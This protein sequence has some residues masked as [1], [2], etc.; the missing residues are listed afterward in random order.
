VKKSTRTEAT[1]PVFPPLAAAMTV[2]DGTRGLGEIE[3][4]GRN[5]VRAWLGIGD[6]RVSLGTYVDRKAAM[7]AV[8]NAV[9]AR[10]RLSEHAPFK[11]GLPG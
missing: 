6:E 3:D 7:A 11:S 9:E 4:H 5:D 1:K 8:S 2:Y 10:K